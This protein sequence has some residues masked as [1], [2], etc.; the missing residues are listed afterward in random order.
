MNLFQSG[1][2]TLNSGAK[3]QWKIECDALTDADI[4]TLAIMVGEVFPTIF[5]YRDIVGVSRGGLKLAEAVK[6]LRG[7]DPESWYKLI[8]DDVL[9]TGGSMERLKKELKLADDNLVHGVVIF[10]RGKCPHWV[11]PLFQMPQQFQML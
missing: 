11:V 3:S 8:V 10:A 5:T 4:D 7:T 2:F 6:K 1:N 9:T